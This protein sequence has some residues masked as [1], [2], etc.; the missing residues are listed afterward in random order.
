MPKTSLSSDFPVFGCS[1]HHVEVISICFHKIRESKLL[2]LR[3]GKRLPRPLRLYCTQAA[4][5]S[6]LVYGL[7]VRAVGSRPLDLLAEALGAEM[8][9]PWI[10][11][12]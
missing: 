5:N 11:R 1:D 3:A 12:C 2:T 6:S 10:L 9:S 8:T 7:A 4:V